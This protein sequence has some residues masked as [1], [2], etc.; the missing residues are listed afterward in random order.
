LEK[1][2]NNNFFYSQIFPESNFSPWLGDKNFLD[3]FN[4]I[5]DNSYVDIYRCYE[6]WE[7]VKEVNKIDKNA[8]ILEVGV[9]RG[10]TAAILSKKISLLGNTNKLYLADTFTGVVKASERDNVYIGGEHKDTSI[11]IVEDLLLKN[12]GL[13]NFIL[14]EGVFPEETGKYISTNELIGLCHLDV[15]VYLSAKDIVN[16]LFPRLIIGGMIIFDDY[17]FEICAGITEFVEEQRFMDDRIII[18]NLNGHAI[19]IRVK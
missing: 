6:L 18:H 1:Y 13:R 17:G 15:D 5:K 7:L 16:W 10:G 19:I 8:S 2:K 14:L 12:I 11:Q 3:V 4:A 9:W